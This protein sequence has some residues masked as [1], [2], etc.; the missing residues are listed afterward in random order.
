MYIKKHVI[1]FSHIKFKRMDLSS[2]FSLRDKLIIRYI[3]VLRL[4]SVFW[5]FQ[6]DF[7]II[8]Q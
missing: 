3:E 6:Y 7:D 2:R 5:S 4:I 1:N 8:M